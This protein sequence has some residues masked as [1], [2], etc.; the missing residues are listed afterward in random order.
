MGQSDVIHWLDE[1][2]HIYQITLPEKLDTADQ[3]SEFLDTLYSFIMSGPDGQYALVDTTRFN[4][5]L[6]GLTDP[7]FIRSRNTQHKTKAVAVLISNPSTHVI[8]SAIRSIFF[9]QLL[10]QF[11]MDRDEAEKFLRE[12]AARSPA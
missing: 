4:G 7:K 10:W 12:K 3:R 6:V 5:S 8:V 1:D 9:K 11:F 2:L